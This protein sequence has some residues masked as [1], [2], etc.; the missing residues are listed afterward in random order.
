[1]LDHDCLTTCARVTVRPTVGAGDRQRWD[2]LGRSGAFC[3][4]RKTRFESSTSLAH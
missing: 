4:H 2:E 3:S 1:M